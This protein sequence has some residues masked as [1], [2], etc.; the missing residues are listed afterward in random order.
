MSNILFTCILDYDGGTFVS[1]VVSASV[2]E[3]KRKW[4]EKL[5]LRAIGIDESERSAFLND[6]FDE[7]PAPL[8]GMNGVWCLS[9]TIAGKL[10]ITHVVATA[11][12]REPV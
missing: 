5:D 9:P 4:A 1:Q 3:A 7:D 12:R 8:R 11:E 10:G 6:V 2:D